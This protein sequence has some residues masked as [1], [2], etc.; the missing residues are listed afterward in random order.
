MTALVNPLVFC[1]PPH[2]E[3]APVGLELAKSGSVIVR[4]QKRW[5]NNHSMGIVS[6]QEYTA[7]RQMRGTYTKPLGDVQLFGGIIL[8]GFPEELTL[9]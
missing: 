2:F 4:Q 7:G 5:G 6:E 8:K 3:L 1:H 9:S